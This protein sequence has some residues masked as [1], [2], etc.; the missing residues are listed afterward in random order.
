[1]K[2]PLWGLTGMTNRR[3]CSCYISSSLALSLTLPS[4]AATK[5]T[6]HSPSHLPDLWKSIFDS[7]KCT[8]EWPNLEKACRDTATTPAKAQWATTLHQSK[9]THCFSLSWGAVEKTWR[10]HALS[11]GAGHLSREK[12]RVSWQ[13][14]RGQCLRTMDLNMDLRTFI[15]K[16]RFFPS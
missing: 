10:V 15:G 16:S 2:S 1:M 3:V 12:R 5:S 13:G 11:E 9:S 8:G 7:R 6:V 14:I 4:I